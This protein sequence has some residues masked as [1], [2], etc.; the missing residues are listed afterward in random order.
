VVLSPGTVYT[1]GFYSASL[2]FND[3]M[4]I[5]NGYHT[6][7]PVIDYVGFGV[8]NVTAG[9]Q[10][11]TSPDAN[12]LHRWGPNFQFNVVPGAPA[13]PLLLAAF[14]RGRR[15]RCGCRAVAPERSIQAQPEETAPRPRAGG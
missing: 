10:M 13:M 5:F 14:L 9:L 1:I 8:A 6:V 11:P 12:G 2:N 15:R 7:N 3:G 4:V